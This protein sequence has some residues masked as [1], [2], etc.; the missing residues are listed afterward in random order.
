MRPSKN[1]FPPPRRVFPPQAPTPTRARTEELNK[2]RW[3]RRTIRTDTVCAEQVS[4]PLA[5][6]AARLLRE[7]SGQDDERVTLLTSAEPER[8]DATKWLELNRAYWGIENGLHQRLDVSYHDD[9]C[10]IRDS[11]GIG[12]MG[13]FRRL[14]NS[15]FMHWRNLQR[16]PEHKTTTDFHSAMGE[17]HC[18]CALRI[19]LSKRPNFRPP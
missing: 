18:R 19:A 1:S 17:E 9:L 14:S 12:L 16:H 13:M 5:A 7:V 3:E 8:L 6:Q 11:R 2:G 10:R 4:F 15:L